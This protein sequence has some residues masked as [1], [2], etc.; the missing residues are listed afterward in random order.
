MT[1][2]ISSKDNEKVKNTKALL[3]SANG[4]A[5]DLKYMFR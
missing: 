1:I 3:K 4:L 5:G 2:F